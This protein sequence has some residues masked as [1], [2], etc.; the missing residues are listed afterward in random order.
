MVFDLDSSYLNKLF[1]NFPVKVKEKNLEIL[2]SYTL[3]TINYK[4]NKFSPLTRNSL[5]QIYS[6][7]NPHP[8]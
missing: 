5:P 7:Y 2:K 6:F 3:N 1:N 8:I 4:S